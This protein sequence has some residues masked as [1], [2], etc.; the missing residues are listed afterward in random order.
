MCGQRPEGCSE[1]GWSIFVMLGIERVRIVPGITATN[2]LDLYY[3]PYTHSLMAAI[4]WSV[5]A[6]VAY[7]GFRSSDGWLG[8]GL[9]G[10]AVFS[11]W[12]LD[13]LLH[14]PDLALYD[15]TMKGSG[16]LELSGGRVSSRDRVSFRRHL[17]L[18]PG[19][20]AGDAGRPLRHDYF[21]ICDA[22]RQRKRA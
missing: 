16:A 19:D 12:V 5:G 3:M 8:G 6:S 10:G 20:Q 21:W 15:D 22:G 7:R 4:W 18:L 9:V 11:H 2:P 17:S 13:L 14:R 1:Q